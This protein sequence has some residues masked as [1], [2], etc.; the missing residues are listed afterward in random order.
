MKPNPESAE[1]AAERIAQLGNRLLTETEPMGPRFSVNRAA[2]VPILREFEEH[3]IATATAELEAKLA[4]AKVKADDWDGMKSGWESMGDMLAARTKECNETAGQLTAAEKRASDL[5]R[6]LEKANREPHH[7]VANSWF[8]GN[9]VV[10]FKDGK[11]EWRRQHVFQACA[12][13][14]VAEDSGD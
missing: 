13:T 7:Y 2:I 3:A 11:L 14:G 9:F 6:E 8:V 4:A 10:A 1:Q 5:E 12:M